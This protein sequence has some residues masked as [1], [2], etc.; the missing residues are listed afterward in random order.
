MAQSLRI[1]LIIPKSTFT[2]VRKLEIYTSSY[3]RNERYLLQECGA[4][5]DECWS[6]RVVSPEIWLKKFRKFWDSTYCACNTIWKVGGK[7]TAG[8]STRLSLQAQPKIIILFPAQKFSAIVSLWWFCRKS[9]NL[10]NWNKWLHSIKPLLLPCTVKMKKSWL[11]NKKLE[12]D[13]WHGRSALIA[14]TRKGQYRIS[15]ALKDAHVSS[16]H[17]RISNRQS[18][19]VLYS[20]QH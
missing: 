5:Y 1:L 15:Q 16:R 10:T 8:C 12:S 7:R 17:Q 2:F 11:P 14:S 19:W 18:N 20:W 9:N 3:V 6:P 4:S 13:F